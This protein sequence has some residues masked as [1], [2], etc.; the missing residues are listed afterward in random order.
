MA[1]KGLQ[2]SHQLDFNSS[3]RSVVKQLQ[4]LS[5]FNR[6]RKETTATSVTGFKYTASVK[7]LHNK[8]TQV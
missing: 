6:N 8:K 3:L 7:L 2:D 4:L 1:Q 5:S